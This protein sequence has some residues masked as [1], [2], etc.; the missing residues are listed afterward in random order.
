MTKQSD[1]DLRGDISA[2]L[3]AM[4]RGAFQPRDQIWLAVDDICEEGADPD[5]LREF[6]SKELDRL[7]SEQRTVEASWSDRTDCDRL[8][9]AFEELESSGIVCRQDFTCCGTCGAAEIGAELD[10]AEQRGLKVRGYAFYHQ[11][12][13]E[14]AIEGYGIFLNYGA[15][16]GGEDAALTIAREIVSVLQSHGLQPKWNGAWSQRIH[17]PLEWRRRL[18][19][20]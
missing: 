7:W 1:Q 11:Q 5:A 8:D 4:V 18:V 15:E 12:D 3:T 10:D 20:F 2:L 17:V 6:A 14:G 16:K 13:T 19:C 9:Q